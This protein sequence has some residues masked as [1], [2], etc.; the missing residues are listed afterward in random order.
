MISRLLL[1][2]CAVFMVSCAAPVAGLFPPEKGARAVPVYLV[3]GGGIH[4]GLAV[5]RTALSPAWQPVLRQAGVDQQT[6]IEFGWGE[7]DGYRKPLTPAI[8]CRSLMGSRRT[9]VHVEGS[10][11][12]PGDCAHDPDTTLIRVALSAEGFARLEQFLGETLARGPGGG[13]VPLGDGWFQATGK[14]SAFHTCNNWTADAL[15][16]A[17]CPLRPGPC[18]F[19]GPLV[20]QAKRFGEVLQRPALR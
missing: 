5:P 6:W 19:P 3:Y 14:Y 9:V 8:I 20:F 10:R 17:G 11:S 2:L 12:S 1:L 13:A 16:A 18:Q 4:S 7:D 15:R